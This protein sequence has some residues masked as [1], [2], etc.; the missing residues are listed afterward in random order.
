[1]PPVSAWMV[2]AAL[3]YLAVGATVGAGLLAQKGG[4]LHLGG[5]A[6]VRAH[7]EVLLVGWL[8]QLALG[9]GFWILPPVRGTR[10]RGWPGWS[11]AALLNAGVAAVVASLLLAGP[12][13]VRDA[14]IVGGRVV[15]VAAI[16]LFGIPLALKPWR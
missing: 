1:M 7:R 16:L 8:V 5:G 14:G 11:V 6:L 2:R 12:G 9:V 4:W 13:T 15:E 10:V 3:A